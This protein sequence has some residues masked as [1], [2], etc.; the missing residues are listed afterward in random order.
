MVETVSILGIDKKPVAL[1]IKRKFG[2]ILLSSVMTRADL[3]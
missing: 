1:W 2:A 3:I